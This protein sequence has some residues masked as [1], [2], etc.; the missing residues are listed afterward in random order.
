MHRIR[1]FTIGAYGFTEAGFFG[2]LKNASVD[3]FCD[4]RRRRGVRGSTYAFVNSKRLQRTL[5]E[6]GIRYLYLKDFSPSEGVRNLQ[7]MSDECSGVKKRD[8]AALSG[9]FIAAY[10]AECLGQSAP[11]AFLNALGSPAENVV[12]F[13]VERYPEACHRSVLARHLGSAL[14][15]EPHHLIP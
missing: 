4:V 14:G 11:D 8:R 9:S 2:A 13:C 15:L 12:L 3:T 5:R 6:L 1:L 7:R 10:E